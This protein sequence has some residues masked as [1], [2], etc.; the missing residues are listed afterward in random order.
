MP[1]PLKALSGLD[2]SFLYLESAGTPMHVG[3][4]MFL[5]WPGAK[6]VRPGESFRR[7]LLAHLAERLPRAP[8]LRRVLQEAPLDLGHPM[9]SEAATV[10]LDAHVRLRRLAG[11]GGRARLRT[12]LG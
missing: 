11:A 6:G 12:L 8:A 5:E 1:K 3:S 2:A 9:W 7:T 10:D 4:V